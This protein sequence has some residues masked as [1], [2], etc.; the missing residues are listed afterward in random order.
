MLFTLKI[1]VISMY[2]L[3]NKKGMTLIEIIVAIAI[4]GIIS[5]SFFAMFT[6]GFKGII[7]AGKYSKA[8]YVAQKAM[9]NRVAGVAVAGVTNITANTVNSVALSINF[10]ILSPIT[11]NGKIELIE[12][13]DGEKKINLATFVPN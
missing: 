6:T 13:N 3:K 10:G 12:Y 11:V 1:G 4:L 8:E 5:V 9:E 2:L 7:N